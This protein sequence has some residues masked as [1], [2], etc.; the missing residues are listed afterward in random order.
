M[1]DSPTPRFK[2]PRTLHLPW[3]LG[4]T[5]DDE[6][7]A[8]VEALFAGKR[9]VISEKLD[10][11]NCNFYADGMHARSPD[12]RPHPS[13]DW[14]RNLHGRIAHNIPA[15]FRICGENVYARHSIAY[16]AL[17]S[18]FF[19]FA[20]YDDHNVC[21]S[22]AETVLWAE[23]LGL[24]T[25]PVLYEGFWDAKEAHALD[26]EHTRRAFE[27]YVVRDARAYGYDQH[28]SHTAKYV[29]SRPTTSEHWR[30]ERIVPHGLS[31]NST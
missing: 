21:L 22:W 9:V 11:E 10:G 4:V 28:A 27:G 30:N 3:S 25:V 1:T 16:E 18:Y 6:V 15:G 14:V 29:A 31:R 24:L 17:P 2:Y 26:D 23:L 5:D 8:D 20:V 12:S 19:A 13:Q 7:H